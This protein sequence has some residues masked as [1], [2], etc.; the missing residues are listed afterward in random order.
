MKRAEKVKR[1]TPGKRKID[2]VLK[3]LDNAKSSGEGQ[4]TA[5]CPAHQDRRSSLAV[6]IGKD[7]KVLIHCFSG[8]ELKDILSHLKLKKSDLFENT[9][10]LRKNKRAVP[11]R[12]KK[13]QN[14]EVALT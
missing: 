9:E 13:E 3:R 11:W 8:C 14:S 6:G 12:K 5:R 10:P 4:W 7:G 2:T 1:E